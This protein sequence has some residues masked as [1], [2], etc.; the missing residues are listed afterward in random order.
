MADYGVE[1][2]DANGRRFAR[3][4]GGL[5]YHYWGKVTV[6]MAS[7]NTYYTAPLFGIPASVPISAFIFCDFGGNEEYKS[8]Y[9]KAEVR[10]INGQWYARAFK[11]MAEVSP[12][13][14]SAT[15]YIFVPAQYITASKYGIQCFS[16]AGLK[17]YDS[18]R[19]LLQICGVGSGGRQLGT[20]TFFNR[21]PAKCAAAYISTSAA[22]YITVNG[23]A[24]WAVTK[25]YG[26]T[27]TGQLRGFTGMIEYLSQGGS[28][29]PAVT[30][31]N[32]PLIDAGYYDNFANLGNM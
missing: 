1:L 22:F 11:S 30:I 8:R 17:V 21:T 2:R 6:T 28:A 9:G 19:P 31:E 14:V 26:T 27:T 23:V 24:Y 20:T 12:S 18:A 7:G 13:F 29:P 4:D 15:F 5:S 3:V 10:Q 16:A 32:V 25:Y